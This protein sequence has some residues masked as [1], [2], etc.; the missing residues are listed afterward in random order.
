MDS[1][2]GST[3]AFSMPKNQLQNEWVIG[4]IDFVAGIKPN[5]YNFMLPPPLARN[6]LSPFTTPSSLLF[7]CITHFSSRI[8]LLLSFSSKDY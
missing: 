4:T 3:G 6:S 8:T 1:P 7:D 2:G 5:T